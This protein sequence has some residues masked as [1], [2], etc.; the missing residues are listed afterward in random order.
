MCQD[1]PLLK[2]ECSRG[3]ADYETKDAV[4]GYYCSDT[5]KS[6]RR[7]NGHLHSGGVLCDISARLYALVAYFRVSE[8]GYVF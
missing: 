5:K 8:F 2:K 1:H 7:L 6:L 4:A 3:K